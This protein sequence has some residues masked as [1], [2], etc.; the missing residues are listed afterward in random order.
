MY[1]QER[2]LI[3]KRIKENIPLFPHTYTHTLKHTHSVVAVGQSQ[4]PAAVVVYET[5]GDVVGARTTGPHTIENVAYAVSDTP[6]TTLNP[7]YGHLSQ[8]KK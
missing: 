8:D 1:A 3:I 2:V 7:A 5:V 6:S 4:S